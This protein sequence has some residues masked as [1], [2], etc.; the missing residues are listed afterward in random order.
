MII[1]TLV[2]GQQLTFLRSKDLGY[3]KE[4]IVIVPTNKS[5]AEGTPLAERFKTEL[6]KDPQVIS[7]AI[8]LFSFSE[9]GWMNLGY[10]DDNKVYRNF[11]MNAVDPDFVNTMDLKIIAGRAFSKDNP[12]DLTG[13]MLVNEA[14]VKEY[15]WKDRSVR[16]YPAGMNN[17]LS[18]RKDL[19]LIIA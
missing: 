10:E 8:S 17:R 3:N 7:S 14:L 11:R 16:S 4:H 6:A 18:R 12:A 5:R 15:G 1:G 9:P 19:V 13:S 2:I